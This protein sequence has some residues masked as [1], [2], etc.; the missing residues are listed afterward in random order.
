M[1]IDQLLDR[2]RYTKFD[3]WKY[4]EELR[5]FVNLHP[6]K[7]VSDLYFLRFSEDLQLREV[8]LGPRCDLPINEVREL[9]RPMMPIVRVMKSRIAYKKFAVVEDRSAR[10]KRHP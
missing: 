6:L 2:L 7:A 8:I 5:R 1:A 4:E 9:V 10:P 3:G